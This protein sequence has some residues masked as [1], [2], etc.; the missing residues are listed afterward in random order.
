AWKMD[1]SGEELAALFEAAGNANAEWVRESHPD[2]D[3]DLYLE[4]VRREEPGRPTPHPS[5]LYEEDARA[6][7]KDKP[8]S[9]PMVLFVPYVDRLEM[10]RT[11]WESGPPQVK[12]GVVGLPVYS[13]GGDP[14]VRWG[15]ITCTHG[16]LC[17]ADLDEKEILRLGRLDAPDDELVFQ[18]IVAE[19]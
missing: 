1:L 12:H 3:R 2:T 17:V 4:P 19:A 16:F 18:K 5:I 13:L 15:A 9:S 10:A 14:R 7:V 11:V 6:L 8:I